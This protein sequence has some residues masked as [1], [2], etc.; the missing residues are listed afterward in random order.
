MDRLASLRQDISRNHEVLEIAP[1]FNPIAPKAAGYRTTTLDIFDTATLR[2]RAA[3]DPPALSAADYFS[4]REELLVRCNQ[5]PKKAPT[6]PP[7]SL[8]GPREKQTVP[9]RIVREIRRV[10]RQVKSLRR[11]S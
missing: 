6:P 8:A 9:R 4:R 3:A 11:A 10:V 7:A 2:E 1:W 5:P